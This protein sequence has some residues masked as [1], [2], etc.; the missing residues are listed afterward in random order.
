[1]PMGENENLS[2]VTGHR[3]ARGKL[4]ILCFRVVL[5]GHHPESGGVLCAGDRKLSVE[6][7]SYEEARLDHP[8]CGAPSA[9]SHP[10]GGYSPAGV[11]RKIDRIDLRGHI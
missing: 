1:M 9:A 11:P 7:E 2:V 5:C 6:E 10:H 4:V 8:G 3:D